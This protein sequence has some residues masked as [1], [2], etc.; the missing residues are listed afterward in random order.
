LFAQSQP[1]DIC[2]LQVDLSIYP[3]HVDVIPNVVLFFQLENESFNF[4]AV[5][6]TR[7][8]EATFDTRFGYKSY[9]EYKNRLRAEKLENDLE[10]VQSREDEFKTWAKT[11]HGCQKIRIYHLKSGGR[12]CFD[13]GQPHFTV[14]P[15]RDHQANKKAPRSLVV[16]HELLM[17]S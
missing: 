6:G 15:G 2:F 4:V 9:Q 7:A 5:P 16:F 11:Q 1:T 3:S 10:L 17:Q 13:A 12:L 8:P 14:I